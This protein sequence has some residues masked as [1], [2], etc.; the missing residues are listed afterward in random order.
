[1]AERLL[2]ENFEKKSHFTLDK[3]DFWAIERK[4]QITNQWFKIHEILYRFD[5][6]NHGT[7]SLNFMT[8]RSTI[9]NVIGTM[10]KCVAQK[11]KK[12][13]NNNESLISWFFISAAEL[14]LYESMPTS[15]GNKYT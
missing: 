1:M 4:G 8:N 12:N 7:L 3:I 6:F 10:H 13:S 15:V 9:I 5:V 2:S 11:F 14:D